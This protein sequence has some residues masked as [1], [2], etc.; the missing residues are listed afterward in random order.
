M[1]DESKPGSCSSLITHYSSLF[2]VRLDL[3]LKASRLSPRRTVAQALCDAGLVSVNGVAAKS[4]RAVHVGDEINLRR[5][6]HLLTVRVLALPATRQTSRSDASSLYE[7][8]SDVVVP[9]ELI[10]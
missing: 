7:I 10:D 8:V 2:F 6:N 3:F 1:S 5:R 4:S 9:E